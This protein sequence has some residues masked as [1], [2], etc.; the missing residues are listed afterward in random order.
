[1]AFRGGN[2]RSGGGG[3]GGGGFG[4]NYGGGAMGGR[5]NPWDTA[6]PSYGSIRQG[7]GGVMQTEALTLANNLINNLLRNRNPPSLLDLPGG[8]GNMSGNRGSRGQVC[9][10]NNN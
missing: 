1:M 4:G 7:G 6:N 9:I 2:R 8:G 3:G 10:F 5:M